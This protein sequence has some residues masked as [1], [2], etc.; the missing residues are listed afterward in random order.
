MNQTV[1]GNSNNQL[2]AYGVH[3]NYIAGM[4]KILGTS[5]TF[6]DPKFGSAFVFE[7]RRDKCG[8]YFVKVFNKNDYYP[9]LVTLNPVKVKGCSSF[10]FGDKYMCS[11]QQFLKVTSDKLV[12]DFSSVC[13]AQ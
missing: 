7:L 3:D 1:S 8:K 2:Y 6:V 12:T 5:E 13:Q 11:L 9:G 4:Q 10:L